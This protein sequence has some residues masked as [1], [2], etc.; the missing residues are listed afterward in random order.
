MHKTLEKLSNCHAYFALLNHDDAGLEIIVLVQC[1]RLG[2]H[3]CI[4]FRWPQYM[5]MMVP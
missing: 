5:V 1:F 4:R 3:L 2:V